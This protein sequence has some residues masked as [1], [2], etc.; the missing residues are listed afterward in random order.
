MRL[1]EIL[2]DDDKDDLS[3][4]V[5]THLFNQIFSTDMPFT[6]H[7][8]AICAEYY[9]NH[10]GYKRISSLFEYILE[11]QDDRLTAE[12]QIAKIIKSKFRIKWTQLSNI[13]TSYTDVNSEIALDVSR[14][15]NDEKTIT[16]GSK[17]LS[18]GTSK[19]ES[20]ASVNTLAKVSGYNGETL[21]DDESASNNSNDV[22]DRVYED[23]TNKTGTDTHEDYG[24]NNTITSGRKTD[25]STLATRELDFRQKYIA[26]DIICSDL[27][28]VLTRP[29]Y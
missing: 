19:N 22:T 2:T 10:S 20:E 5:A 26:F 1:R 17:I 18:D 13:L 3:E 24:N 16:Y 15:Y 11:N 25:Y 27:D 7:K 28:T 14:Q 6:Q 9:L 23:E 8:D 29:L 21:V 12:D 4:G